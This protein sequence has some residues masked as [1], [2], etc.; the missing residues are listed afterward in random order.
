MRKRDIMHAFKL[1]M[2]CRSFFKKSFFAAQ[3][4]FGLFLVFSD[5]DAAVTWESSNVQSSVIVS[6]TRVLWDSTNSQFAVGYSLADGTLLKFSTSTAGSSWATPV[7]TLS[8]TNLNVADTFFTTQAAAGTGYIFVGMVAGGDKKYQS[9]VNQGSTWSSTALNSLDQYVGG[10]IQTDSVTGYT[11]VAGRVTIG[12]SQYVVMASTTVS[13]AINQFTSSTIAGPLAQNPSVDFFYTPSAGGTVV[14]S[15]LG[16]AALGVGWSSN[17]YTFTDLGFTPSATYTI[18]LRP[19]VKYDSNGVIYVLSLGSNDQTC[20]TDCDILLSRYV[21][22]GAWTTE[23]IDTVGS[24]SINAQHDLAFMHGTIPIITYY[25]NT[26]GALRYAYKD[27]GNSGCTGS[28]AASWT[29]GSVATG[30]TAP[31]SVAISSNSS[32]KVVIAYQDYSA[33]IFKSAYATIAAASS[34]TVGTAFPKP[35]K[36]SNPTIKVNAGDL[37]SEKL[38]VG[39]EL[40]ATNA[41]EVALS[42]NPDFYNVA[43]QPLSPKMTVKL[44]NKTGAQYVYAKF[45]NATGGISDVVFGSVYYVAPQLIIPAP[46]PDVS[47]AP[48]K[49]VEPNFVVTPPPS[50]FVGEQ[51][52]QYDL[53]VPFENFD[54]FSSFK[55]TNGV[56]ITLEKASCPERVNAFSLDGSIIQDTKKALYLLMPNKKVACPVASYAVARS[57]G[58]SVFKKGST[59]GYSISSQLPYRPGTIVRNSKTRQTFFVNTKGKLQM[60]PSTK[61]FASLGYAKNVIVFEADAVLGKFAQSAQLT[62]TDMHPDGTLF[63]LDAKKGEYAILQERALHALTKKTLLK[64]G[65]K[66]GRAVQLAPGET[67][68]VGVRWD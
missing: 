63:V 21:G 45:S 36:P 43:W 4:F 51:P 35:T 34:A 6:S 5:A 66:I 10:Q 48:T 50:V 26:T 37:T 20:T 12:V 31:P 42:T 3:V 40:S 9:S 38:D 24:L 17:L 52:K 68:P 46:I 61:A 47:P 11:Y 15:L 64:F 58:V 59:A 54:P 65:E 29:C 53:F 25:N 41:T 2:N 23:V 27:S 14:Y 39:V 44:Q 1:S 32:S 7:T 56:V 19:R 57:W 62:R 33:S 13:P 55:P 49:P 67:Y 60:F 18:L 8:T 28:A 16:S 22:A 30:L